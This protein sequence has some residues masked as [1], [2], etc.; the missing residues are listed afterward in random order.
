MLELIRSAPR[1]FAARD[2]LV[3]LL[4][5]K[6]FA[7]PVAQW[8]ATNLRLVD[9]RYEW[10]FDLDAIEELLIDFF[11]VDL[12]DVIESH[13]SQ[14]EVHIVKARESSVL[15]P[16]AIARVRAAAEHNPRVHYHEIAGGH[17]VNAE[18]P[19]ALHELL[20]THL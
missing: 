9:G 15:S 18:N 13:A 7:A 17:W 1:S 8:M 5:G 19:A 11:Q 6:G 14:A 2:E 10:R 12:W 3:T 16:E 20:V 4:T